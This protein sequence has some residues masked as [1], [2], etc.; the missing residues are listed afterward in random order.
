MENFDDL[1]INRDNGVYVNLN[2][3][4]S[5][6]KIASIEKVESEIKEDG[7]TPFWE[8]QLKKWKDEGRI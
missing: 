8:S 3:E 6:R 4:N 5:I 2:T 7:T 1:K